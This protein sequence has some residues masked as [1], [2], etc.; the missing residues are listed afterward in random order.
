MGSL[1]ARYGL[2]KVFGVGTGSYQLC[3]I[4]S[5]QGFIMRAYRND[6]YASQ[7]YDVP[8]PRNPLPRSGRSAK[9]VME[10]VGPVDG[11]RQAGGS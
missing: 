4:N 7:W 11:G 8:V 3:L 10:A 9:L 2:F 1:G 5:I 6:G